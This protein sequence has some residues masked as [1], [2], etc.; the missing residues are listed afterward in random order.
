MSLQIL[1]SIKNISNVSYLHSF[2]CML[3]ERDTTSIPLKEVG[4]LDFQFHCA[5]CRNLHVLLTGSITIP[6]VQTYCTCLTCTKLNPGTKNVQVQ[7][8]KRFCRDYI[9]GRK[10]TLANFSFCIIKE[11]I[12]IFSHKLV[13]YLYHL[14]YK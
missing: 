3:M 10:V 8:F 14:W 11:I 12:N 5:G 7:I 2:L 6:L 13:F 4:S 1:S 9:L